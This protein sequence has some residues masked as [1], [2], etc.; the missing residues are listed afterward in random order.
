MKLSAK[1]ISESQPL[2]R[3]QIEKDAP[4]RELSVATFMSG[5]TAV[6]TKP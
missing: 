2:L 1:P 4:V 6:C 5:I 3:E